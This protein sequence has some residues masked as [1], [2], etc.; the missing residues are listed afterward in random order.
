[1]QNRGRRGPDGA[2][3]A[4]A[5][6]SRSPCCAGLERFLA[7]G[8]GP[9]S[10]ARRFAP[11]QRGRASASRPLGALRS[12]VPAPAPRARRPGPPVS[13]HR[14]TD[15][16]DP[17]AVLFAVE[18]RRRSRATS[19]SSAS[20]A[21]ARDDRV[22]RQPRQLGRQQRTAPGLAR[23]PRA[24]PCRWRCSGA[25]TRPRP[26]RRR[27]AAAAREAGRRSAP[28]SPSSTARS[29][30][31]PVA[32]ESDSSAGRSRVGSAARLACA[33]RASPPPS[34]MRPP[35]ARRDELLVGRAPRRDGEPSTS[36]SETAA[37]SSASPSP[38]GAASSARS[39]RPARAI[40]WMP[41][42]AGRSSVSCI[43]GR[44]Y[45][46]V[47]HRWR[48]ARSASTARCCGGART[49]TSPRGAARSGT[50]ARRT[51]TRRRSCSRPAR[52]TRSRPCAWRAAEGLTVT[53]RSGGHSWAGNHLRD[54]S[55][56]LDLSALRG[57]RGRRGGD[58]GAGAARLPRQ[59]AARRARAS[60]SCSSPPAT[61]R[62]WA[63][64]ATCCRAATAGT[65][66]C[67]A[68]PA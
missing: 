4:T 60:T 5:S 63:S 52:P 12:G 16:A 65:G 7:H 68:R 38:P 54:G 41:G 1:M 36:G 6:A 9:P 34:T 19:S 8:L 3:R 2:R 40:A 48:P 66:A 18:R 17:L 32:R 67:T 51:A 62:A 56:L 14:R 49:A 26:P 45:C 13:E 50:R 47:E 29:T 10:S 25:G 27:A 37:A 39:T 24:S 44:T 31:S 58:D 20:S 42:R 23:A 57:A 15:R 55:V 30:V 61:A 11:R 28:T 46:I 22:R 33:S 43:M 53:V 35:G 21:P 64:A 59:R